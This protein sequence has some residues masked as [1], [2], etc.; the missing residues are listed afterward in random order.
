MKDKS[1]LRSRM[2]VSRVTENEFF[3][4]LKYAEQVNMSLS[5]FLRM[6]AVKECKK[7]K[8]SRHD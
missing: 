2:I 6:S 4:F 1:K 8:E 3:L 7:I 5:D